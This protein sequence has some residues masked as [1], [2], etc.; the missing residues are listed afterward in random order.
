[1]ASSSGETI[2]GIVSAAAP[3]E[4]ALAV[5]PAAALITLVTMQLFGK[6]RNEQ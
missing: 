4:G 6:I 1:M 5:N 2:A 3:I